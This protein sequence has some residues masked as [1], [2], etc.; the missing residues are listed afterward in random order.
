MTTTEYPKGTDWVD[1]FP[2]WKQGARWIC[3]GP[4]GRFQGRTKTE[5]VRLLRE[6]GG[7]YREGENGEAQR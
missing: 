3:D 5:T 4:E 6:S 2:V 7:E 1:G